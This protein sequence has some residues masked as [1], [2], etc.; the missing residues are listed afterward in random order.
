MNAQV[1]KECMPRPWMVSVRHNQNHYLQNNISWWWFCYSLKYPKSQEKKMCGGAIINKVAWNMN[2]I[3]YVF[4]PI[5]LVYS[6]GPG[7]GPD[8]PTWPTYLTYLPDLPKWPAHQTFNRESFTILVMFSPFVFFSQRFVLS[9]SHC[10]C[11]EEFGA[12]CIWN[13][14][15]SAWWWWWGWCCR[16][17]C[18]E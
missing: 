5:H 2:C 14:E 18:L 15:V 10:F 3:V 8:L 13:D 4:D 6:P 12:N 16:W 9:A 11:R 7:P 1:V 17:W